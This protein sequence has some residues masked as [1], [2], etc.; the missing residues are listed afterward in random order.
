[1]SFKL[2]F[3]TNDE[4]IREHLSQSINESPNDRFQVSSPTFIPDNFCRN[5]H[6]LVG[7]LRGHMRN[8]K[9]TIIFV[10][11]G[12]RVLGLIVFKII[13]VPSF[14]GIMVEVICVP[15][16]GEKGTG[17]RLLN[18]VKDLSKKMGLSIYLY[19][20][21]ATEFYKK[22]GFK[23]YGGYYVFSASTSGGK[24]KRTI[25]KSR[26]PIKA[27]TRTYIHK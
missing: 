1:M 12:D 8:E 4:L 7:T 22:N 20:I 26:K 13:N 25:R 6:N 10:N 23:E 5:I 19:P 11:G 9:N 14:K 24:R 2:N 3:I 15:E 16:T 18:E 27:K 17:T 21:E